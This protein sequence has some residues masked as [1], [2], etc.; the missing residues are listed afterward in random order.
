MYLKNFIEDIENR[1]NELSE[2]LLCNELISCMKQIERAL[3]LLCI[4]VNVIKEDKLFGEN[5]SP[6]YAMCGMEVDL[7]E[8][9]KEKDNI[10]AKLKDELMLA[11]GKNE[12]LD[13]DNESL[14]EETECK[15]AEIEKYKGLLHERTKIMYKYQREADELKNRVQELEELKE[16]LPI[17]PIKVADLLIDKFSE[18]DKQ[19]IINSKAPYVETVSVCEGEKA[20]RIYRLGEHSLRQIAKHLLIYCGDGEE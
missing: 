9:D 18:M 12:L 19:D 20:E 3:N 17:E 15:D 8:H 1:K 7:S 5:K 6:F 10:I 16:E 4:K 2:S 11:K 14:A 13:A